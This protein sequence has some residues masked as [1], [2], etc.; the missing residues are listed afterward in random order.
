MG[1]ANLESSQ[2]ATIQ[3]VISNFRFS[4]IL[5]VFDELSLTKF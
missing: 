3:K 2:R 5:E 4:K 1:S